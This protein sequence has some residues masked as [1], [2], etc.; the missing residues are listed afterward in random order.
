MKISSHKLKFSYFQE[1]IR[2]LLLALSKAI[3][4]GQNAEE[5]T[6]FLYMQDFSSWLAHSYRRG[7]GEAAIC[8]PILIIALFTSCEKEIEF[9]TQYENGIA[10]YAVAI[11]NDPFSL[12]ISRSFT[13]NDNPKMIFSNYSAYYKEIDSLYRSQIVIKDA[14]AEILVNNKDRYTLHYNT[15]SPYD[16]SCDYIP[17]EG[18]NIAISV[19]AP[20]YKDV[21][22]TAKVE[23]PQKIDIVKTEIL[24]KENEYDG[25]L[26]Y[27]DPREEFGVDTVMLITMKI[28]DDPSMHNF[29]RLRIRGVAEGEEEM[30]PGYS[31]EYYNI[32]DLF[33]SDDIIFMDSQLTKSYAGMKAGMTNV[34][35][36]HL[37][38]GQEYTFTVETRKRFG[39]NPRVIV[40]LQSISQDLYYFLKS[41]M[42]FR[43][44]TDDVYTT[45]VGLYSNIEN[46]WGIFGT[47]SSD[48]HVIYY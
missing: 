4:K 23:T 20:D 6:F 11:P 13:V 7:M 22:A 42:L 48:Q 26:T 19:K 35:D 10:V 30:L 8:F 27:G 47:L 32:S 37:F 2:I 34:F 39:K 31:H 3:I 17:K 28:K 25:S 16:Y 33:T 21:Y 29:Y 15:E 36:D 38:N 43:I 5:R 9:N 14:T 24:N 46:G 40:D 44:S 1:V 12:K 41:Y 18:D 45:P